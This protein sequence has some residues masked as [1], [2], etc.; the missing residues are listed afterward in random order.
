MYKTTFRDIPRL[1]LICLLMLSGCQNNLESIEKTTL[2]EVT[3][4]LLLGGSPLG[5]AKIVFIP[6]TLR[7]NEGEILPMYYGMTDEMGTFDLKTSDGSK[8]IAAGQYRV[9]VSRRNDAP[10]KNGREAELREKFNSLLPDDFEP[11]GEKILKDELVPPCYNENTILTI[12]VPAE[13]PTFVAEIE[14]VE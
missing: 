13:K 5:N 7:D 6:E 9:V 4:N 3:G 1:L 12:E 10:P 8:K 14:L 2:V 11:F